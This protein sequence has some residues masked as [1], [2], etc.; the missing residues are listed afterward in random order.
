MVL[1]MDFFS[2]PKNTTKKGQDENLPLGLLLFKGEFFYLDVFLLG[3][4]LTNST[5]VNHHQTT[6]WDNVFGTFSKH[7]MQIHVCC[8]SISGW[9]MF[10][11]ENCPMIL[12]NSNVVF[13]QPCVQC[14]I[15]I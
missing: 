14:M 1:G 2:T 12:K 7:L 11:R 4:F 8:D 3:V 9:Q 5:M 15:S 6:I 13:K 10:C